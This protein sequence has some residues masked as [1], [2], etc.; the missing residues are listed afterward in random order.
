MIVDSYKILQITFKKRIFEHGY[1]YIKS[2]V[3]KGW[4]DFENCKKINYP[5]PSF[6]I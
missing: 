4:W 3:F 5:L 2:V 1:K 6:I